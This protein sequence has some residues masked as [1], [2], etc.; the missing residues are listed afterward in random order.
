VAFVE[1]NSVAQV[2]AV[3]LTMTKF[4]LGILGF[5]LF[6]WTPTTGK[7]ILV[8]GSLLVILIALA[9]VLAKH[10]KKEDESRSAN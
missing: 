8:Y 9:I 1:V 7:G 4:S 10:K 6:R 2:R 5:V 3:A